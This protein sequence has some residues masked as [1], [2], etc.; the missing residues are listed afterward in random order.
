ME[1]RFNQVNILRPI[2]CH[3]QPV[4]ITSND[5]HILLSFAHKGLIW[6]NAT[7]QLLGLADEEIERNRFS[8]SDR[9]CALAEKIQKATDAPE[10]ATQQHYIEGHAENKGI[11]YCCDVLSNVCTQNN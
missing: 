6:D 2:E 11:I 7:G 9:F 4:S 10:E 3:K 8:I 1:C 5:L